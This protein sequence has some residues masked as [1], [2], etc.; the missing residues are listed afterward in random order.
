MEAGFLFVKTSTD[1]VPLPSSRKK[2]T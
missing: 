1:C 2:L